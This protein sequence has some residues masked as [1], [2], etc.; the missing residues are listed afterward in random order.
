MQDVL[1]GG[2]LADA[3]NDD[4]DTRAVRALN[5]RARADE[6]VTIS[7]VPIGDGLLLARKRA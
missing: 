5:E 3:A 7:L 2:A 1:R 4:E 6:R